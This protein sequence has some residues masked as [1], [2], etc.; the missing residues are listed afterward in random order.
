MNSLKWNAFVLLKN[1][2]GFNTTSWVAEH[3]LRVAFDADA[4]PESVEF[5]I[6]D[7]KP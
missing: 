4:V 5:R 2:D 1:D 6:P 7:E 3:L